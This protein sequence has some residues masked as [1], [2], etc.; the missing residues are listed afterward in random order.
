MDIKALLSNATSSGELP[1]E[2]RK[3]KSNETRN[4]EKLTESYKPQQIDEQLAN[5]SLSPEEKFIEALKQKRKPL[6]TLLDKNTTIKF[7]DGR[8]LIKFPKTM[9]T[10]REE[11]LVNSEMMKLLR[12]AADSVL[13]NVVSVELLKDVPKKQSETNSNDAT[14]PENVEK[15]L[16]LFEAKLE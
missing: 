7:D 9:E 16:S 1:L 8:I 3:T 13:E 2:N 6:A 4:I 5:S 12:D 10:V 15:I 14:V 11:I